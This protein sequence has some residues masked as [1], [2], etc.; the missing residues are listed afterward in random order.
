MAIPDETLDLICKAK[1]QGLDFER[2]LEDALKYVKGQE[3]RG[4]QV[5]NSD[6]E[7]WAKKNRTRYMRKEVAYGNDLQK[8]QGILDQVLP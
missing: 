1:N 8:G 5:T 6:L 7:R 2:L 3:E 4:R